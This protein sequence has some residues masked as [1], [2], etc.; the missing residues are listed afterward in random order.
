MVPT[1]GQI[2]SL[3][4]RSRGSYPKESAHGTRPKDAPKA[5]PGLS[6]IVAQPYALP[7]RRALPYLPKVVTADDLFP[8][9]YNIGEAIL[10]PSRASYR[11]YDSTSALKDADRCRS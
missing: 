4:V 8:S 3:V 11:S 5:Q 7:C 10:H 9:C 2:R 6:F 1:V